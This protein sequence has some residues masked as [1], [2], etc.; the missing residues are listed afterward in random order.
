M[1]IKAK[2]LTILTMMAMVLA[3]FSSTAL[4][5]DNAKSQSKNTITVAQAVSM[6]VKN[7]K[8]NID[9]IR[10]IKEPQASDYFTKVKNDA[11]YANDFIIAHLNGLTLDKDVDPE[12]KITREHFA[13]LLFNSISKQGEYA[14]IEIFIMIA[15]EKEITPAYMDSI[16]KLLISKIATLDKD[17]KFNP[18]AEVTR[19]QATMMIHKGLSFVKKNTPV[20]PIPGGDGSVDT[21][22]TVSTTA[23]NKD[24]NKVTISWG[25]KPNPGY[26]ISIEKIEFKGETATV[27]YKLHYPD[28]DKMYI[29]MVVEPIA[30][31][32]VSSKL[33]VETATVK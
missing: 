12:K 21:K 25:E 13:E 30:E 32:F 18:K 4:A 23:V 20:E 26:Q 8:L 29:Q 22:V 31:A 24:I 17:Q 16:Q 2:W 7:F 33:R 14:F 3:I 9:N 6:L 28:P 1:K 19:G 5:V 27:Y 10:F 11:P 15:D